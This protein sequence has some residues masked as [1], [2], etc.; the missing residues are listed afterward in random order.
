ME[1][2]H[3]FHNQ[4]FGQ[5]TGNVTHGYMA[6]HQCHTEITLQQNHQGL[7][8][9]TYTLFNVFRMS[10]EMERIRLDGM[11]VDRSCHQHIEQAF[12]VI[13][14]R[15]FQCS[16]CRFSSFGSRLGQFHL[17]LLFYA[18]HHVH[19]SVLHLF[20]RIYNAETGLYLHGLAVI[21]SNLGR[22]VHHRRT[23]FQHGGVRESLQYHFIAYPVYISMSDS[24]SNFTIFH[25]YCLF[26]SAS[27]LIC[28]SEM[29]LSTGISDTS[30]S[31]G[32]FSVYNAAFSLRIWS[33]FSLPGL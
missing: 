6:S 30:F 8:S 11:L 23:K 2:L 26:C 10:R 16:Q 27:C 29:E 31:E 15:S 12:P 21:R 14:Q 7:L 9:F 18:V 28:S 17:Q 20:S 19:S 22:T 24:H 33:R 5:F 32:S 1:N 13:G 4:F 25:I 3:L